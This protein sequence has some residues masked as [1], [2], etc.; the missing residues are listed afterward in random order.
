MVNFMS[1]ENYCKNSYTFIYF[2]MVDSTNNYAKKLC[3]DGAS[4]KTVVLAKRQTAGKGRLGRSFFSGHDGIYLSIILRPLFSAE[5]TLF[6]TTAA[7]VAVSHAIDEVCSVKTG[8]KWVND[9]Y[10]NDKKICGIL[11]ESAISAQSESP[12]YAVLG[13][14]VN[15]SRGDSAVPDEIKDIAGFIFESEQGAEIKERLCAKIL[16]N[17]FELYS[18]LTEKEYM[19]EYRH[20]SILIGKK[21]K[22]LCGTNVYTATVCDIDA[23][24]RL[25]VRTDEGKIK[26]L[27][28]G[29][30]SL[31]L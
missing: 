24:A 20:R 10:L 5:H 3:I 30:V 19:D 28:A 25:V 26:I 15:L 18:N 8:I 31:K 27:N 13:I 2:E 4:E 7:A 1:I 9:I 23:D 12:E 17:F 22:C 11:T 16:D 21:V 6:I 14:G 29:E